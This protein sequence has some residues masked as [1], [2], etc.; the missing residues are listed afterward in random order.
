MRSFAV[1]KRTFRFALAVVPC[2]AM[3]SG[4]DGR[5]LDRF[6]LSCAGPQHEIAKATGISPPTAPVAEPAPVEESPKA[7]VVEPPP[8]PPDPATV[9][10][11]WLVAHAPPGARVVT[12]D[13]PI[14]LVHVARLGD[15]VSAIAKAYVDLTTDYTE[16]ELARAL[17]R[18]NPKL[19][20]GKIAEGTEV[21][22][23]DLVTAPVPDASA[24]R[25]GW[26]EDKSLRG[27]YLSADMVGNGTPVGKF[28][29]LLDKLAA[30]GMNAVVVDAKDV[31]GW[32]TYPSKIP[33]ALET[34]GNKHATISSFSR[35]VRVAHRKGIRVVA[36]IACFRDEHLGPTRGDLAIQSKW[37]KPH[38]APSGIVDWLDPSNDEVQQYLLDVVQE[39]LDTGV[40][41]IQLDYVRYPTEGVF[42][43]DF[44][45][46]EKGL[47]TEDVIAGFVKR[48][49]DETKAAGVPLS[50]DVFGC[51]AWQ[52]K[53]DMDS[54]GQ[55]LKRLGPN[56]EALSPMV[57]PSHFDPGFQGMEIP[58]DHPEIV[59]IGTN[60]A[61][62]TLK[63]AGI[64]NVVVRPWVQ[65]FPWKSPHF[66]TAYVFE[67]IQQAKVGGGVG[68]LAWNS[69]GEYG[70]TFAAVMPKKK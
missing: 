50:L 56:I 32:F 47:T 46:K 43:A 61:I 12:D 30:R 8:P 15:T 41:E 40:D 42:D 31:T 23:P 10:H 11:D 60:K 3:L 4:A 14:G 13:G 55:D 52:Y 39:V 2:A 16:N 9:F 67:Q 19:A 38:R 27:I 7:V 29:T 57:Y 48:V 18:A 6:S 34:N 33:M 36:R 59:A 51:V 22:I 35:L 25:L 1:N 28:E 26:P 65:A 20:N 49:H 70:A 63:S 66:G 24:E 21:R 62:E 69:G 58:G 44:H 45:L 5:G 53:V 68:F 17:V 37:G 54:T 64:T